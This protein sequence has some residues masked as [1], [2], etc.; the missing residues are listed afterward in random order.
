M[1][2]GKSFK[3]VLNKWV[4]GAKPPI[5]GKV[6]LAHWLVVVKI[7]MGASI[8]WHC[9][10]QKAFAD[11]SKQCYDETTS[12]RL[13]TETLKAA[14]WNEN[15]LLKYWNWLIK[16]TCQQ[17]DQ[18]QSTDT[19]E[20]SNHKNWSLKLREQGVAIKKYIHIEL[21][22]STLHW[23]YKMFWQKCRLT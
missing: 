4:T 8:L 11:L 3:R 5:N 1:V 10:N 12:K 22:L 9:K 18:H 19:E 21:T 14:S 7:P 6:Q 16:L 17:L 23:R 15:V 20:K 13:L 2:K